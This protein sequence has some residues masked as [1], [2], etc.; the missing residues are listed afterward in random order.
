MTAYQYRC[1]EQ[2][3]RYA[4]GEFHN[5]GKMPFLVHMVKPPMKSR[6]FYE[7]LGRGTSIPL[8]NVRNRWCTSHLKLLPMQNKLKEILNE[9]PM[10]IEND[11]FDVLLYN[12]VR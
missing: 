4:A 7:L 6:F 10:D 12:G 8:G 3:K 1:L 2:I 11:E 9:I 5:K